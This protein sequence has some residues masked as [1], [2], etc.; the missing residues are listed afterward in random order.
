M[1]RGGSDQTQERNKPRTNYPG[2]EEKEVEGRK[3]ESTA[4]I[5]VS[6]ATDVFCCCPI[7]L[8]RT[9]HI[10][11]MSGRADLSHILIIIH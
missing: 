2:V 10:Q 4:V 1:T 6:S 7:V 3:G 9:D 8:I 11:W 5:E